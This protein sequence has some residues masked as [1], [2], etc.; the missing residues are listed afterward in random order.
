MR[1]L[2]ILGA[3]ACLLAPSLSFAPQYDTRISVSCASTPPDATFTAKLTKELNEEIAADVAGT[4]QVPF[5]PKPVLKYVVQQSLANLTT[6]LSA[7]TLEQVH[8][9]VASAATTTNPFDDF[10]SQERENLALRVAQELNPKLDVPLLDEA[11]EEVVLS[12]IFKTVFATLGSP[13]WQTLLEEPFTTSRKLLDSDESRRVLAQ[14]LNDQVDIPLLDEDQELGLLEKAVTAC[15]GAIESV[16]PTELVDTLRGERPETVR[17]TKAFLVAKVNEKVDLVGF[18]EEQEAALIAKMVDLL[19]SSFIDGTDMEFLLLN[20]DEKLTKVEEKRAL[21]QR[22]LQVNKERH[23][24]EIHNLQAK[25]DR[26][27]DNEALGITK[28]RSRFRRWRRFR[29]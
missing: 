4:L 23:A 7:D 16:L 26:L 19:V 14:A 27:K 5:L 10:T 1:I 8:A 29:R 15:A 3:L 25:L 22:E 11:Q 6:T 20:D 12:E 13:T 2:S 24:R 18:S 21:L 28:K 9:L 17:E